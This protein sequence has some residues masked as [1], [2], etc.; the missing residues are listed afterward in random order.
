MKIIVAGT[1]YVGLVSGTCLA[2]TG[3]NVVCVDVDRKK[4]EKLNAGIV[5]IYE[6]GLEP[7]IR[8]NVEK[9]RLEFST[10]IKDHIGDVDIIFIAV[11]TPPGEDGSADM[12]YVLEVARETGRHMND[13]KVIVTKSTVPVGT[14]KMI[15]DTV[16][17]ELK[18]RGAAIDFDVASNPEFLKE[19][20]A[21]EDFM[22]PDRIILGI[23]SEKAKKM[24][25]RLYRPFLLNGHPLIY[26]DIPSAELTKYAANCML[27]T[28]ISFM[29]EIANLCEKVGADINSVRKGIGSDP[30]IGNKF[31][32]AGIGY[33]GSCFPK[34]VKAL[35]KTASLKGYE[36]ELIKA[37]ENVNSRQK[38]VLFGKINNHFGGN[39]KNKVF[40]VWGLSFKPNTNDMREAP[41]V[42]VI[43]ELINAGATVK[44]FDPVAIPEAKEILGDKVYYG[45][46]MYD[47]LIDADALLMITEWNEFRIPNFKLMGK[48]MKDRIIFDGRNIYEPNEIT[49]N[50]FI[51]YG[52]GRKS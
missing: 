36:T 13:Y 22:K 7:M 39:L 44:V 2:E 12:K 19:G 48:I 24:L 52:I 28:K 34:D 35:I 16:G 43:D 32:Y 31:I 25:D 49:E 10:A 29:N 42:V 9:K 50:G 15:K 27:A 20:A 30:R 33:G 11:G 5:P 41:S 6:P 8:R 37:V 1:G 21:V 47:V 14:S 26:M 18:K 23:E 46:D 4:I 17:E 3:I 51:Y 40:G 38:K 45:T